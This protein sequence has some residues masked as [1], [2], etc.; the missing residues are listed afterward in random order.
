[1]VTQRIYNKIIE[2]LLYYNPFDSKAINFNA[3]VFN[4]NGKLFFI[5]GVL[6]CCH[7]LNKIIFNSF[8]NLLLCVC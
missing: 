4:L 6:F 2:M 1:M 7:I 8:V 5:I 3:R